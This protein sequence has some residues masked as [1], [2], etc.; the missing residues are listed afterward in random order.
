LPCRYFHPSRIYQP[1]GH[2]LPSL[3][4]PLFAL[5]SH[6]C[7]VRSTPFT[8][9]ISDLHYSHSLSESIYL[10][11][12]HSLIAVKRAHRQAGRPWQPGVDIHVSEQRSSSIPASGQQ[13]APLISSQLPT[14]C[15]E[16]SKIAYSFCTLSL[17]STPCPHFSISSRHK[18]CGGVG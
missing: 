6:T 11:P 1:Q 15:H 2:S 7:Q 17:G 16:S 12:S 18:E 9:T 3:P 10:Y 8:S 14:A 13:S 5:S 4:H